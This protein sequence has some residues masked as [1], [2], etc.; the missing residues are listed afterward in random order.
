MIAFTRI[1]AGLLLLL[2]CPSMPVTHA[3]QC[4]PEVAPIGNAVSIPDY[5]A[6]RTACTAVCN[7]EG[8][9]CDKGYGGCDKVP[10]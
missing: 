3:Q 4:P 1:T 9:C 5:I 7:N 8:Y 6:A 2:L 10:W